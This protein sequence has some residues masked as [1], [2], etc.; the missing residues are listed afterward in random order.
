MSVVWLEWPEAWRGP[1][2]AWERWMRAARR[3]AGTVSL[4]VY[5]LRMVAAVHA[6][7]WSVVTE[8]LVALL[9]ARAW[10]AETQRGYRASWCVFYGWAHATGRVVRDPARVLPTITLP[11]ALPRPAPDDVL[12]EA[13]AG[14]DDRLRVM[15][16]LAAHAGLRR[17][18]IARVHTQD[19][20]RDLRGP[21]LRVVGKGGR[22]RMVPLTSSLAVLLGAAPAG[23]VFPG[24]DAGHLSPAYVGKLLSEALGAGWTA[25]TL[26]HRFATRAY[27]AERDL[28]AVQELLG[29]AKPETTARYT[30][31]PYDAARRAVDAA[32]I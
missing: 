31:V 8:D 18:E 3:S 7:P 17:G 14:A 15:L 10:S 20:G 6:D 28:R 9:G 22:V 30:A 26:R 2:E 4:R 25:H 13:L 5:H 12:R 21:T 23:Y 11:R 29:H 27:L 32:S 24:Q 16:L 1:V 19:L